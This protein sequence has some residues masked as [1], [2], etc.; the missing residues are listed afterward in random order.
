MQALF[1]FIQKLCALVMV[2]LL[3]DH[4]MPSGSMRKYA[5]LVCGM[6]VLHIMVSQAFALIGRGAPDV[7]AQQWTQLVGE[8]EALPEEAGWEAALSAYQ[9]Q[10]QQMILSRARALGMQEP[11]VSVAWR[12]SG[13]I[14]AVILRE[15]EPS[16]EAGARLAGGT[17]TPPP[18]PDA[19]RVR[20]AVAEMLGLPVQAVRIQK[21]GEGAP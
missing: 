13:E 19:V 20:E 9:R 18:A 11:S 12:A 8:M 15:R 7:A 5:R 6:L 14:A 1:A 3:A 17:Q 4:L 2:A 21:E 16:V 10:A